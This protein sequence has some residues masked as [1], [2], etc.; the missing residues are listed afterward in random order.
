MVLVSSLK[1]WNR[2]ESRKTLTLRGQGKAVERAYETIA[3]WELAVHDWSQE[4]KPRGD[5]CPIGVGSA[6]LV[7][8]EEAQVTHCSLFPRCAHE[9]LEACETR[10]RTQSLRFGFLSELTFWGP[11]SGAGTSSSVPYPYT[12]MHKQAYVAEMRQV[13]MEVT[14]LQK[15]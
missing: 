6:W 9:S 3:L 7:P 8:G 1:S 2:K 4:R 14:V 11:R 10:R 5:R 13:Q 15:A 12:Q